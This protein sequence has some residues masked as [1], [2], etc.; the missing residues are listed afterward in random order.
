M[1]RIRHVG[2]SSPSRDRQHPHKATTTPFWPSNPMRQSAAKRK[3]EH[4]HVDFQS[5]GKKYRL[6]HQIA[7]NPA[8]IRTAQQPIPN[9]TQTRRK[10]QT[11]AQIHRQHAPKPC[12]NATTAPAAAVSGSARPYRIAISR[13]WPPDRAGN[14]PPNTVLWR[15]Q[16]QKRKKIKTE[17]GSG[18]DRQTDRWIGTWRLTSAI[19]G[20]DL[21]VGGGGGHWIRRL[22]SRARLRRRRWGGEARIVEGSGAVR[23]RLSFESRLRLVRVRHLVVHGVECMGRSGRWARVV[24]IRFAVGSCRGETVGT[25]LRRVSYAVW[26]KSGVSQFFCFFRNI[27]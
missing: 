10:S 4:P 7:A 27:V 20:G 19:D 22:G 23:P 21:L 24:S 5:T 14:R 1:G 3:G 6:C 13:W 17:H 16:I 15:E 11:L 26:R 2:S 8:L 9:P 25:N 12:L 18:R